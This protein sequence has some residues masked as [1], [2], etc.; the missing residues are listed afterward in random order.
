MW[1]IHTLSIRI[2]ISTRVARGRDEV[3]IKSMI[4]L[5]LLKKD[6]LCYVQNVRQ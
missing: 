3:E 1:V 2:F 4:A 6:M 5:V